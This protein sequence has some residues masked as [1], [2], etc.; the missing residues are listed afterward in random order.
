[1]SRL[2]L[3]DLTSRH[4]LTIRFYTTKTLSR[5]RGEQRKIGVAPVSGES[6]LLPGPMYSRQDS[7]V[8]LSIS[9][10]GGGEIKFIETG[11]DGNSPR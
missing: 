9:A 2:A 5:R 3:G 7:R 6:F 4:P 8:A 10:I 11:S 1:M